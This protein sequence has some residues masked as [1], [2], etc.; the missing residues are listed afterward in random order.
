MKN[1][2]TSAL[3]KTFY[4]SKLSIRKHSPEILIT[5][6]VVGT[7]ASVVLAC[8]STLK[9][10][11]VLDEAKENIDKIHRYVDENGFTEK[12]TEKEYNSD[13]TKVYVQTGIEIAKEY[14]PA[15]VLGVC[16]LGAIITSNN[17][18]RKRYV[19]MTAAYTSIDKSFKDYRKHVV[20]RFG[21]E[22]DKELKFNTKA[23]EITETDENGK[24]VTKIINV[25]EPPQYSE[26]ARVYDD[27][28]LGWS[29]DP[30]YNKA[31]LLKQQDFATMKLKIQGYLFLNEVYE[32]LGFP[33]TKA[34]Q[35]VGWIYNE[36]NPV[37]DNYVD[38]GIFNT[39]I[40]KNNDFINGYERNIILDF[41]VDGNILDL[42]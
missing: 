41:N 8:K 32:M 4:K 42:M 23:K 17:I 30:E 38:F 16:S 33:K 22:L 9:I 36:E 18:L 6:G 13:L 39:A 2:L 24:E 11:D 12:Y 29:K 19:A 26:Y 28:C 35:I 15:I 31:S 3:T 25:S 10:N 1:K 27:G 34:G 7:V 21:E 37:G 20:E 14:A 5:A 40:D